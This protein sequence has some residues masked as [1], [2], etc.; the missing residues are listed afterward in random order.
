M[1]VYGIP[2]FGNWP[3]Y[4]QHISVHETCILAPPTSVTFIVP[5]SANSINLTIG[6]NSHIYSTFGF[7]QPDSKINV[8]KRCQLGNVNFVS[9]TQ[10]N[11]GDDVLMA[12]GINIIDSDHHSIYWEDRRH[13]VMRCRE[14]FIASGGRIIGQSQDWST[15]KK[16]PI[17]IESKVWIGFNVIVLKGVTIGEGSVIGAGSVVTR[18]IPPWSLAAGNPC[19]VLK[20]IPKFSDEEPRP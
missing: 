11:V 3:K 8:G 19:R 18:D 7:T 4:S 16:V 15:V 2:E 20:A 17:Y 14:D 6:E 10:I 9:T 5:P 13:D 12:W 1:T